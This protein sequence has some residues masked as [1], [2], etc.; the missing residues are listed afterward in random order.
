MKKDTKYRLI[1][2]V[3]ELLV[4]TTLATGISHTTTNIKYP[5]E[6]TIKSTTKS[7]SIG[8]IAK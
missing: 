1:R 3:S 6:V 8:L 2:T 4:I 7:A 5:K